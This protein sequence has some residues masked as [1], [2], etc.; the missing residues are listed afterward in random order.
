MTCPAD[1]SCLLTEQLF[2]E[3]LEQRPD[4]ARTC[5]GC[6]QNVYWHILDLVKSGREMVLECIQDTCQVAAPVQKLGRHAHLLL[7]DQPIRFLSALKK[8]A[9]KSSILTSWMEDSRRQMWR[10]LQRPFDILSSAGSQHMHAATASCC[11]RSSA[12]TCSHQ[13]YGKN[14]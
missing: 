10:T 2:R 11:W 9:K 13:G 4:G 3:M 1:L 5:P 12:R 7:S 14:G 8:T 6:A